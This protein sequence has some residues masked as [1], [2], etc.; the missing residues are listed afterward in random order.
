MR[1]VADGRRRERAGRD[2]DSQGLWQRAQH[3]ARAEESPEPL[4]LRQAP[5]GDAGDDELVYVLLRD[6]LGDLNPP[7]RSLL[8]LRL[9]EDLAQREI[10]AGLQVGRAQISRLLSRTFHPVAGEDGTRR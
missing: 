2:Q 8:R 3:E 4:G 7:Q 6:A 5:R 10:G 9:Y 1:K